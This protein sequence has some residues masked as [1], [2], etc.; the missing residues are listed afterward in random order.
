MTKTTTTRGGIVTPSIAEA[1]ADLQAELQDCFGKFCLTAGIEALQTMMSD[2]VAAL[3]GKPHERRKDRQGYRWGTTKGRIG[4]QGGYVEVERP[5]VRRADRPA[6]EDA[7]L[8]LPSWDAAIAEDWLARTAM[9]LML[10]GVATRRIGRAV[11]LPDGRLPQRNGDGTSKSAASRRFVELSQQKLDAWLETPLGALDIVAIQIDGLHMGDDLVLLGAIGID[12]SGEKH[13]LGL[14]EGATENAAAAQALLDDLIRRGLDPKV[15]RLFILDGA[16]ALSKAVKQ[17]FGRTTAIQRCQI[18]KSRNIVERC[19]KKHIASVKRT[20]RAAWEMDDAAQADRLV[21]D[22]VERMERDA[23]S[24]CGSLLEGLD[25]ML[26]VNR[27]GLPK[28]LRRSLACT[29]IIENMQGTI[30]RV[31]RNVKRW[32]DAS[33][34][35][36]WAAAGMMEAKKGFRRL[37]ACKQLPLL[38]AALERHQAK[39]ATRASTGKIAPTAKAA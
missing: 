4:Y 6:Q 34:A 10:I 3:C 18:H 2:D 37:K 30:R 36:R 35:M 1:H 26:T 12:L 20:L 13:V 33:M 28:A 29:N 19:P 21:R 16:K 11:R 8:S 23:P 27:L 7:E 25:E 31:T 39:H 14:M 5:R 24:L 32:R 9:N 22:L 15:P 17:T 38:K